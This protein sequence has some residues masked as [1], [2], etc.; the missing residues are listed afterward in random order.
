MEEDS[1]YA[2]A[3]I[4]FIILFTAGLFYITGAAYLR[5]EP[6]FSSNEDRTITE[7]D[8]EGMQIDTEEFLRMNFT[9][10]KQEM[11]SAGYNWTNESS[12]SILSY[13]ASAPDPE[14]PY[15]TV[16]IN[17]W[18]DTSTNISYLTAQYTPE[19]GLSSEDLPEKERMIKGHIEEVTEICNISLDP[20]DIKWDV[21]YE[22][23]W[24]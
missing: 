3:L 18:K 24:D 16:N 11:E 2:Y 14:M 13:T 20:E 23:S 10:V 8:A 4:L 22:S 6:L 21:Y 5:E 7:I 12:G 15:N 1:R 9:S 17:I 19:Y